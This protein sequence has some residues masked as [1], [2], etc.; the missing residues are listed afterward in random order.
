MN[1]FNYDF[2]NALSE[3]AIAKQV[4]EETLKINIAAKASEHSKS[5]LF[6]I[7]PF[8]G[9]L[10]CLF[11]R[12]KIPWLPPHFIFAT[13]GI[14]FYMLA[15]LVIHAVI[16]IADSSI[17]K[18]GIVLPLLLM[19]FSVFLFLAVQRVYKNSLSS[20]ILKT[21]G[22]LAGF[23]IVIIMYRQMITIGTTMF[24]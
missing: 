7:I 1:T 22:V 15:D 18:K 3:K 4:N 2:E 9:G 19:V 20:T 17:P 13:H 6:L 12:K 14:T 5:L 21:V 11:F 23:I 24:F 8:W 10:I 16:D